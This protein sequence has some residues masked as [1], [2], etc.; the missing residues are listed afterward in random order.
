M[1]LNHLCRHIQTQTKGECAS[2]G[3]SEELI[4]YRNKIPCQSVSFACNLLPTFITG[5]NCNFN[6]FKC[7]PLHRI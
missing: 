4:M 2:I 6:S 1:D 7:L 5:A 3:I